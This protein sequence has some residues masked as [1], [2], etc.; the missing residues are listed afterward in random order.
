MVSFTTTVKD[1]ICQ[2]NFKPCCQKSLLS[3]YTLINGKIINQQGIN[4]EIIVHSFHNRTTRLVY[5]FFKNQYPDI[6]LKIIVDILHKFERP[7]VYNIH[8]NNNVDF[9]INDLMFLEKHLYID[10]E[11]NQQHLVKEHCTR[12]YIA[13]IFLVIGSI[14]SP[15]TSNYHLELQFS[16]DLLAKKI[17]KILLQNFKLTFKS[18]KRRNKTVLYLKKSNA[19]SDFLKIID[20]PQAVFAFEDK[21]ISR[22]LFNNINR[23]NNIDISNQQ[24]SLNAANQQVEMINFLKD[25]KVFSELSLKTQTI[26]NLRVQNPEVSLLELCDLYQV[27]TGSVITKSGVNH[28]IREIKKKYQESL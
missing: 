18:I 3:S 20:C 10:K 14:N 4:S 27:A 21:R 26:S 17:K 1:E 16:D 6:S 28:L 12:A 23:F 11:K 2:K 5:K 13:G 25:K 24:K 9:I 22:E 7:K 8:I 19:I 15:S